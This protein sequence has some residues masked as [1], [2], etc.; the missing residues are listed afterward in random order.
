MS[1][2]DSPATL[3]HASGCD[4]CFGTGYNDRIV[5]SEVLDIDDE[6]RELIQPNARSA[7]IEETAC[8]KGMAT[9]VSDGLKK[10]QEGL[11]TIEEVRRVAVD[12]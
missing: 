11:T 12:V 4:R 8:R 9:M 2:G 7:T 1:I 6:I 10:C 3:W 5:I